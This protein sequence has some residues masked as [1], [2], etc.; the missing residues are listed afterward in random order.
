MQPARIIQQLQGCRFNVFLCNTDE[1]PRKEMIYLHLLQDEGQVVRNKDLG[2]IS[3]PP[4][5]FCNSTWMVWSAFWRPSM[6]VIVS[7]GLTTPSRSSSSTL[8]LSIFISRTRCECRRRN[9]S[10]VLL[11]S[12]IIFF[13]LLTNKLLHLRQENR[14]RG[15]LQELLTYTS[16]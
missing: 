15:V 8:F 5:H 10:H 14:H 1:N 9:L 4:G 2:Q 16:Q 11:S 7:T 12:F 3:P 13:S 6:M